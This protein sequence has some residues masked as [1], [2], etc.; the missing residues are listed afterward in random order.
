MIRILFALL[1]ITFAGGIFLYVTRPT[2]DSIQVTRAQIVQY[3]AALE[4]AAELEKRKQELLTKYNQF[5][6]N[7][8][9]RLQKML[10][11]HVDNIALIL[12]LDSLASHYTMPIENVDVSLPTPAG[13]DGVIVSDTEAQKYESLTFKF[14]TRGNY[15]T[16]TKFLTDLEASL[17]MIDLQSLSISQTEAVSGGA[18]VYKYDIAMRTYWL[19]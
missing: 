15:D 7:D 2:Y 1:G 19:R 17:R 14:S 10:P 5:N 18:P 11:D 6:P 13:P 8:I 12:D 4:K 3:D 9:D 16:F